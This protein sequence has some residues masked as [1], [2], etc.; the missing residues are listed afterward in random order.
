MIPHAR[1][2]GMKSVRLMPG[3]S[4]YH[5]SPSVVIDSG[6]K[7]RDKTKYRIPFLES[8]EL[9]MFKA[10]V[11]DQWRLS[12]RPK[13]R[14]YELLAKKHDLTGDIDAISIPHFNS[15]GVKHN[16]AV[17]IL[18]SLRQKDN[19]LT[20]LI[21]SQLSYQSYARRR[22][23]FDMGNTAWQRNELSST[24]DRMSGKGVTGHSHVGKE[25][26]PPNMNRK[27]EVAYDLRFNSKVLM[28][29]NRRLTT[30]YGE[31]RAFRVAVGV[32]NQNG[33]LGVG[34][35]VQP[36]LISALIEAKQAAYNQLVYFERYENDSIPYAVRGSYHKTELHA[37]PDALGVV[38]AQRVVKIMLELV[39]YKGVAVKLF[40]RSTTESIIKAF[41]NTFTSFENHQQQAD[42]MGRYVVEFDPKTYYAPKVKAKPTDSSKQV[43]FRGEIEDLYQ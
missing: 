18:K 28:C 9:K 32:G 4:E 5:M 23:T 40:G 38:K 43:P 35:T 22:R 20:G 31:I 16:F 26:G 1:H 2:F 21:G 12:Y 6:K 8:D 42:V 7:E 36:R 3:F 30:E 24:Y 13:A 34:I 15:F 41:F 14:D 37:I 33:L 29:D 19:K 25:F 17:N 10:T 39:G 11:G 27:D